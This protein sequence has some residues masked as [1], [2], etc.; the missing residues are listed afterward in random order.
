MQSVAG[1]FL[2]LTFRSSLNIMPRKEELNQIIKSIQ[3]ALFL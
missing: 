2:P 3:L 1:N